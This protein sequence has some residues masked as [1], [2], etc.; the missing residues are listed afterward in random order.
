MVKEKRGK[1]NLAKEHV[2]FFF[3][4][5]EQRFSENLGSSLF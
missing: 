3:S 5:N 1:V 2:P 4:G